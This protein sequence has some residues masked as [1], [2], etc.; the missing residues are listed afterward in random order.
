MAKTTARQIEPRLIVAEP[1]LTILVARDG[2]EYT[3]Y[4]PELDIA[5]AMETPDEA[6]KVVL[7]LM[8]EYAED[9]LSDLEAYARS[10][11]RAHHLPYVRRI[12]T[13]RDEW[14]LRQLVAVKYGDIG[15][16]FE[17]LRRD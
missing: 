3:A 5:A 1:I 10:P 11:N 6:V 16:I 17:R 2:D 4:C 12:A 14:Q 7:A 15:E 8:R 9:Y 13:C